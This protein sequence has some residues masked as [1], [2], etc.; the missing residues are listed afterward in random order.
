MRRETIH[1]GSLRSRNKPKFNKDYCMECKYH[2]YASGVWSADLNG[3]KVGVYCNYAA[4]TDSTCLKPTG[5]DSCMDLRGDDYENCKLFSP[6]AAME[7]RE[8]FSYEQE[9]GTD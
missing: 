9:T 7:E 2:G 1:R 3:K 6:G 5:L 8:E 4:V